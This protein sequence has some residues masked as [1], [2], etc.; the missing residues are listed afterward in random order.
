M[1]WESEERSKADDSQKS[2]L[3]TLKNPHNVA[4]KIFALKNE[5]RRPAIL[6]G[7]RVGPRFG[8]GCDIAVYDNCNVNSKSHAMEFGLTYNNHTGLDGPTFFAGSGNFR[9]KEIEVFEI[10]NYT[11]L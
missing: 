6:C 11:A 7:P 4:A 8:S 2:F 1:K 5:K 10:T 3:F 9:V